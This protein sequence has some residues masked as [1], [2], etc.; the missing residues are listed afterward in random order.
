MILD[1]AFLNYTQLLQDETFPGK[2]EL[3]NRLIQLITVES[4]QEFNIIQNI[5][6]RLL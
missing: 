2:D 6:Y 5:V 4:K 3:Q 1:P